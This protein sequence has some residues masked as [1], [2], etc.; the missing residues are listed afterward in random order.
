M[1]RGIDSV[2]FSP[3]YIGGG[4]KSLYSVCEWLNDLGRSTIVP[5][6]QPKLASWFEH[7]CELYD[8]SYSPDVLI[9]PEVYQPYFRWKYHIC[10]AL[11]KYSPIEPHANLV[12]CKSDAIREWVRGQHPNI[13]TALILPS[14][15]RSLF[16]YD[17]RPKRDVICYMTR[18]RKHPD[19]ARLL[20]AAYGDKVL[21][22]VDYSEA[23]VAEVLRSAKVFV[24]RGN[25]QEGSPRPPKEALV[26]GC[27]VVGLESDLNE[28]YHTNWGVRCATVDELIHMA[29]RALEMPTPSEEQR[30]VVRDSAEEK[31]DW[32]ALLQRLD[33]RWGKLAGLERRA[34]RLMKATPRNQKER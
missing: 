15:K 20:R 12:V 7:R 34:R 26:A 30:S 13:P 4:V 17:G 23:E 3:P 6:C 18:P 16:E 14:I 19:T 24:W 1:K 27:V 32:L 25:E 2:V 9:Y 29:G 21:E 28:S 22:I 5:T 11:G 10:F 33:I 8:S 31:P